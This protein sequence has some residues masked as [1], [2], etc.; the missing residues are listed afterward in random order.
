MFQLLELW[1]NGVKVMI[2]GIERTFRIAVLAYVLDEPA[3]RAFCGY[4]SHQ[5]KKGCTL[6]TAPFEYS[7]EEHTW[8]V[9]G[10]SDAWLQADG[11]EGLPQWPMRTKDEHMQAAMKYK[12]ANVREIVWFEF[13]FSCG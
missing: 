4:I 11:T 6:C 5:A 12:F 13:F 10:P 3:K 9:Q 8:Y 7:R 2:N 1:N